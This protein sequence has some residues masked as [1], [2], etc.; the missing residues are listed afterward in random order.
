MWICIAKAKAKTNNEELELK[1]REEKEK[2]HTK[3]TDGRV[4]MAMS[5]KKA[6][7]KHILYCRL[8]FMERKKKIEV[9]YMDSKDPP[10]RYTVAKCM[11]CANSS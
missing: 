3:E 8:Q 4:A 5:M 2:K 10:K 6:T 7:E 1:L 9:C 11:K